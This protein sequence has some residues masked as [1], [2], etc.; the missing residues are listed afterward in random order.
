MHR[1][2]GNTRREAVQA[3]NIGLEAGGSGGDVDRDDMK[4]SSWL[5]VT[6]YVFPVGGRVVR[7]AFKIF[8]AGGKGGYVAPG[9]H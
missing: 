6:C 4:Q 3:A 5:C 7:V 2:E 8:P 1:R 9:K